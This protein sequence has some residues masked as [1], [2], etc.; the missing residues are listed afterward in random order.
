[1]ALTLPILREDFP[2]RELGGGWFQVLWGVMIFVAV[3]GVAV[4]FPTAPA[5]V[6]GVALALGSVW[7]ASRS[8]RRLRDW[9]RPEDVVGEIS[10]THEMFALSVNGTQRVVQ[11]K[12]VLRATMSANHFQ[13]GQRGRKDIERN[14]ISVLEVTTAGGP[15]TVKMLV[16][17]KEELEDILLLLPTWNYINVR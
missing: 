10:I 7:F 15:V 11:R 13:G 9:A 4:I 17:T 8:R 3:A 12:D 14:G 16:R 2:T 6:F 5:I 1:M